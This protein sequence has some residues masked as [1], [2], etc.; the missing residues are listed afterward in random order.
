MKSDIVTI[1]AILVLVISSA[2]YATKV[3]EDTTQK[4][5]EKSTNI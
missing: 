3:K 4:V 2:S 1:L 5:V